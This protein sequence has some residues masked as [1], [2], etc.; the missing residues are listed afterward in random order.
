MTNRPIDM[1][2]GPADQIGPH[3]DSFRIDDD[4]LKLD[5]DLTLVDELKLFDTEEERLAFEATLEL[6]KRIKEKYGYGVSLKHDVSMQ[7]YMTGVSL[8]RPQQATF[9]IPSS[10]TEELDEGEQLVLLAR[11]DGALFELKLKP[12]GSLGHAS[13]RL[14][15]ASRP[16]LQGKV[17]YLFTGEDIPAELTGSER[18]DDGTELRIKPPV[19][20]DPKLHLEDLND[21]MLT[22]WE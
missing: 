7:T 9:L 15:N 6:Q 11:G 21:A 2:W 17:S 4:E 13:Q 19:K 3:A 14:S 1:P 20:L 12:V 16:D 8:K 5:D 18:L 22:S 10:E